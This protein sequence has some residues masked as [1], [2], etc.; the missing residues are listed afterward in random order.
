MTIW[1]MRIEYC[2]PEARHTYSEYVMLTAFTLQQLF[3]NASQSFV[4]LTLPS[5]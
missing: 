5:C 3:M 1:R 4:F 2:I